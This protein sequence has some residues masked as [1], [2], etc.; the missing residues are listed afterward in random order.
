MNYNI[1]FEHGKVQIDIDGVLDQRELTE[2]LDNVGRSGVIDTGILPLCGPGLLS[3][4]QGFG[5]TQYV[6]QLEPQKHLV[7]WGATER[8][9][10]KEHYILA[11][12]WKIIIA[13]YQDGNFL[14]LRHFYSPEA[15]YSADQVLYVINLPN[16]NTNGY[17]DTSVGW[18]CLY[19]TDDTTQM[20]IR[21]QINYFIERESGANEPYN[22]RNMDFTDGPRFYQGTGAP[23]YLWDPKA[24]HEKTDKEGVNWIC[25]RD[26]LIEMR[27][28]RETHPFAE[29]YCK[30]GKPYTLGDAMYKPY[31]PYYP[32]GEAQP[33]IIPINLFKQIVDEGQNPWENEDI[34]TMASQA[35]RTGRI[36]IGPRFKKLEFKYPDDTYELLALM[37]NNKPI[38]TAIKDLW[39]SDGILCPSCQ[40]KKPADHLFD[41]VVTEYSFEE[42]APSKSFPF[43][44]YDVTEQWCNDCSHRKSGQIFES[45]HHLFQKRFALELLKISLITETSHLKEFVE[46]CPNCQNY[47]PRDQI[48][49]HLF[50]DIKIINAATSDLIVSG[51][52]NHDDYVIW[53]KCCSMCIK[54][55]P[56]FKTFDT[57]IKNKVLNQIRFCVET[58]SLEAI[59][60]GHT[61]QEITDNKIL[62]RKFDRYD[63]LYVTFKD[64]GAVKKPQIKDGYIP[65]AILKAQ[66][67]DICPCGIIAGSSKA[68]KICLNEKGEY[69]SRMQTLVNFKEIK[70][71]Y[72]KVSD[73]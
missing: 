11:Q 44:V 69:V 2:V 28:D 67:K 8:Q 57:P 50:I 34:Q 20:N 33:D 23:A 49:N 61:D 71:S 4:R 12:P 73:G 59:S 64:K 15:I 27:V 1:D 53:T 56:E 5:R 65:I 37:R 40:T 7:I 43:I 46:A 18:T 55:Y 22:D 21:E 62:L 31:Y 32:H 52:F 70:L 19:R 39:L 14:G 42:N 30:T 29:E 51:E 63:D 10:V 6:Y 16:T 45:R 60:I 35:W 48:E 47:I 24:W 3:Y 13:D 41:E 68:C 9:T 17:Q 66:K 25:S 72:T 58:E 54:F 36:P 38:A 26:E